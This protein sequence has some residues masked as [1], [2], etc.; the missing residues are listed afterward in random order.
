MGPDRVLPFMLPDDG[1]S[2]WRLRRMIR[3]ARQTERL[4]RKILSDAQTYGPAL[5]ALIELLDQAQAAL[6]DAR[7]ARRGEARPAPERPCQLARVCA[8]TCARGMPSNAAR[9]GYVPCVAPAGGSGSHPWLRTPS[10]C[11][12]PRKLRAALRRAELYC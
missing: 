4:G 12:A 5:D 3:L 10:D 8:T 2:A 7:T 9:R 1:S 6:G 11:R